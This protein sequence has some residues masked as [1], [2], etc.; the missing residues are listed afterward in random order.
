MIDMI[1]SYENEPKTDSVYH[2]CLNLIEQIESLID[3]SWLVHEVPKFPTKPIQPI[4]GKRLARWNDNY[5]QFVSLKNSGIDI[6]NLMRDE[7]LYEWAYRQKTQYNQDKLSDDKIKLLE[8]IG[9]V[10]EDSKS[11]DTRWIQSYEYLLAL[12]NTGQDVNLKF[13]AKNETGFKIGRWCDRQ[14]HHFREGKL[15]EKRIH[16]L[17]EIGFKWSLL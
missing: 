13:N 17:E 14:R 5:A 6:N 16:L 8:E 7:P 1:N 11:Y 15:S 4:P 2:A 3:E 12:H 10:W 9:F